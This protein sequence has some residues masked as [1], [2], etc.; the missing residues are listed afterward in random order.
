ME[1]IFLEQWLYN[2]IRQKVKEDPEYRQFVGKESIARLTSTD[3]DL[4]QLFKLKKIL[5]YAYQKS[6]FYH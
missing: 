3:V 2:I 6:T 1:T 5:S 4:Y